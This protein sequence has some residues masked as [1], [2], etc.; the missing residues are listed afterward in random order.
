LVGVF[1]NPKTIVI[2]R[3]GREIEWNKTF[4]QVAIDYR[5]AP[6][7]CTPQ[8]PNE[9]GSVEN[10]VGFV[11]GSFFKTR[12]FH[13]EEDLE[14]QLAAWL[15]EVNEV[16][17]C[18]ATN[19]VPRARMAI[20]GPRLREL[21]IA[22]KDYA[23]R[24]AVF[25]GPTGRVSFEGR[26]YSMSPRT[27]GWGATLFLYRDQVKIVAGDHVAKHK[28]LVGEETVSD[29]PEHRAEMLAAVSGQRARLYYKR[30]RILELGKDA[31]TLLTEIVHRHPRSW[32][33]EVEILY[34]LLETF[35]EK[36]LK[37]S[38]ERAVQ[39][40]QFTVASVSE[41]LERGVG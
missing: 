26:T 13:D 17:P 14:V 3:S 27:I 38:L 5:F 28:R 1:D 16:R 34:D 39:H 22:P 33:S 29:L 20:E 18:R 41:F 7:L 9:K 2:S 32:R 21:P 11:K 4:A 8:H 37:A 23:L 31:E 10:L 24:F 36:S 35:G 12:V 25:V 30:Q 40:R 19:E 6:E 15:H